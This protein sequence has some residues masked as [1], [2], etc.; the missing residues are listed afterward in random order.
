MQLLEADVVWMLRQ[1]SS[2]L[3]ATH[4]VITEPPNLHVR[5]RPWCGAGMVRLH[6]ICKRARGTLLELPGVALVSAGRHRVHP[7]AAIII[8]GA[9]LAFMAQGLECGE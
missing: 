7:P 2:E 3:A 5:L 1:L 4:Q 6:R 8:A 9:A